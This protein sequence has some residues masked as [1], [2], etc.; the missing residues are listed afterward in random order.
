MAENW[1]KVD[2][3][4]DEERALRDEKLRCHNGRYSLVNCGK[5]Y[6]DLQVDVYRGG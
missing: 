5:A 6:R 2:G 1:E 4:S 3:K